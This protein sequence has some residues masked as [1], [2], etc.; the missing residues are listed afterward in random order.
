MPSNAV[1]LL[2]NTAGYHFLT[3]AS[4]QYQSRFSYNLYNTLQRGTL[5]RSVIKKCTIRKSIFFIK[6]SMFFFF[7]LSFWNVENFLRSRWN[8]CLTWRLNFPVTCK[9]AYPS[10]IVFLLN[11]L[12]TEATIIVL[13]GFNSWSGAHR[14][15]WASLKVSSSVGFIGSFRCRRLAKSAR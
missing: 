1:S 13:N 6:V 15:L 10:S 9:K 2:A 5:T 11:T 3:F 12:S 4:F 7:Q 14:S 8:N